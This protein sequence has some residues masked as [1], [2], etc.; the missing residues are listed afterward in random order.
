[1]TS[2]SNPT[3]RFCLVTVGATVGFRKLTEA[4]LDSTFWKYLVSQGF[5]E[6]HV[7]CGPDAAWASKELIARKDDAPRGLNIDIFDMRK[8]L[9]K[10]EMT[11]CKPLDG[12]RQLGLV[13]SHAGTGTI[14]DAWKL[15]LPI[16]V[17]PNT[18]LLNDHQ[19]EMAK[20]LS[21]EGYAIMSTGS[22]DDLQEAMHKVELLWEDNKARWPPNKVPS[23]G[24]DRRRLWDLAPHE[25]AKEQNA[26]MAHD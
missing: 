14:L 23:A 17:V 2:D 3:G 9:M 5:T 25:V 8:N 15:G 20:H 10:E 6:L 26:T 16:I 24:N 1:M 18:Q 7:Q 4:A 19:T 21:K 11:L 13:I 12:K 22:V